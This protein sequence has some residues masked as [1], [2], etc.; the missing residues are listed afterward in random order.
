MAKRM[1]R[2]P[3]VIYD[4]ARIALIAIIIATA[5]NMVMDILGSET[6]YVDSLVLPYSLFWVT[7]GGSIVAVLILGVYLLCYFLSK[8]NGAWMV[9]A[10]IAGVK[11]RKAATLSFEEKR[12]RRTGRPRHPHGPERVC[13][14]TLELTEPQQQFAFFISLGL[15]K[16]RDERCLVLH[17]DPSQKGLHRCSPGCVSVQE[18]LDL[19]AAAR[20]TEL[21]QCLRL[22][23]TDALTGDVELRTDLL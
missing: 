9:S 12:S 1:K 13:L 10:L 19:L 6:F 16:A 15:R 4:M 23:L 14:L 8:K 11:N 22:D 7:T 18:I 5:L 2:T 21:T 3:T 17:G 20:M